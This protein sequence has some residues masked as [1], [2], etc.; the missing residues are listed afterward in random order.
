V[1][2]RIN[3][4]RKRQLCRITLAVALAS[5]ASSVTTQGRR[6]GPSNAV[7]SAVPGAA[8]LTRCIAAAE[9]PV[10]LVL[11]A[12][13]DRTFITLQCAST[14]PACW[15]IPTRRGADSH[16]L[17]DARPVSGHRA[18][19]PKVTQRRPPKFASWEKSG[20]SHYSQR[21]LLKCF[22]SRSELGPFLQ[23]FDARDGIVGWLKLQTLRRK[24]LFGTGSRRRGDLVLLVARKFIRRVCDAQHDR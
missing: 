10:S 9:R 15:C 22:S 13:A 5:T 12:L 23:R 20:R 2:R 7:K 18:L 4:A 16:Q 8:L 24:I 17:G 3:A 6:V 1:R 11:P 14:F 21:E 19:A